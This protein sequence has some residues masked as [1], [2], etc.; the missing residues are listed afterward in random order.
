MSQTALKFAIR[1]A[2]AV[3][4]SSLMYSCSDSDDVHDRT[5]TLNAVITEYDEFGD[6]ILDVKEADMSRAGFTFG[7]VVS[8]TVAGKEIIMPYYDGFYARDAEYLCVAYPSYP[9][10]CFTVNNVGLP[11]ELTGLEG[12]HVVIRMYEKGGK[13][14]VQQLLSMKYSN[15]RDEYS[16]FTDAEFANAR[17]VS[18]GNIAEG[19]LHRASSP[20][21]NS[22]NRA[23]YVSEYLEREQ[24]KTVLNLADTEE[25]MQSYDLPDYSKSLWEGGNVMLCPLNSGPTADSYNRQLIEAQKE[26]PRHAWRVKTAPAM[27]VHCLRVC[28]VQLTRKLWRTI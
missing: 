12:H 28:A 17:A 4:L 3:I 21:S 6:A 7:D 22:I 9:G 18:A 23:R 20:F 8:L 27:C 13:I 1:V 15:N 14:D 26:L 19:V 16:A 24:V 2:T 11:A 25:M 10:I 5:P